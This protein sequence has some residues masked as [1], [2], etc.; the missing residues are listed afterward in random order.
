MDNLKKNR[1]VSFQIELDAN[2][3]PT[4][5]L[6][7]SSY[8]YQDTGSTTFLNPTKINTSVDTKTLY[9]SVRLGS[10]PVSNDPSLSFPE[11]IKFNGFHEESFHILGQ[12]N[13]DNEFNLVRDIAVSSN[14]IQYIIDQT[15]LIAPDTGYDS[16]LVFIVVENLNIGALTADAVKSN[17]SGS[18]I[19]VY[20][21]MDLINAM[22]AESYSDSFQNSL[23]SYIDIQT[24]DFRAT[25]NN[26]V[27]YS[28][29]SVP[30]I[31]FVGAP[32]YSFPKIN[33]QTKVDPGGNFNLATDSY[34]VPITG[35]YTLHLYAKYTVQGQYGNDLNRMYV[36]FRINNAGVLATV[37]NVH[38]FDGLFTAEIIVNAYL[39]IGTVLDT[40]FGLGEDGI[41][42]QP[43]H[44][45]FTLK[46]GSYFEATSTPDSGGIYENVNTEAIRNIFVETD[47]PLTP[48]QFKNVLATLR[49][50]QNIEWTEKNRTYSG[51]IDSL[52]YNH[53]T[54]IAKIILKSS[55]NAIK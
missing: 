2:G 5:R 52:S 12:C 36:G 14:I 43:L 27:S 55:I 8:F 32:S 41:F 40:E 29:I 38:S 39:T 50:K 35:Y 30:A 24:N 11:D 42:N 46:D 1:D 4:I 31:P 54:E 23:A 45:Y 17:P 49:N 34:T 53:K 15:G 9:S 13:I 48:Q 18:G 22:V 28:D 37:T 21:N 44:Q 6:E 51:W 25:V 33:Y 26:P 3:K 47:T 10:N 16:Q 7:K 19:P 20:Y